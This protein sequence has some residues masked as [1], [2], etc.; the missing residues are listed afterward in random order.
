MSLDNRC[1]LHFLQAKPVVLKLKDARVAP[2]NPDTGGSAFSAAGLQAALSQ[3]QR[4]GDR[5]TSVTYEVMLGGQ[6]VVVDG[7][8][9]YVKQGVAFVD[10]PVCVNKSFA[11]SLLANHLKIVHDKD[12]V[13]CPADPQQCGKVVETHR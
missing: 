10:C 4:T 7:L 12:S 13:E 2:S 11:L 5:L 9:F 6:L 3:R 8:H 1:C